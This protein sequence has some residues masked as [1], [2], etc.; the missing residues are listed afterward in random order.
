MKP[1]MA[2]TLEKCVNP[3]YEKSLPSLLLNVV[4]DDSGMESPKEDQGM[5]SSIHLTDNTLYCDHQSAVN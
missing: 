5:S 3:D 2:P 1:R 4:K